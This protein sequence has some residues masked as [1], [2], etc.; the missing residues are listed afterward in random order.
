MRTTFKTAAEVV[1][2]LGAVQAQDYPGA[3]WGVGQRMKRASDQELDAAL[4]EGTI[5]RTH[6]MRPTWHFVP[7]TDIK[8]M[9]AL[10]GPRVNAAS[11]SAYRSQE[12]DDRVLARARVVLERA[13]RDHTYLT[14]AEIAKALQQARI[15]CN[16]LRLSL[17]V[18]R[19]EVDALICSGPRRG[20]H[21]TYALVDERAPRAKTLTRD[22]AL[23]ELTSRYFASHGPATIRDYVWWSGLTVREAKAGVAMVK[24][25]FEELSLG[26]LTY[27]FRPAKG[28]RPPD[29]PIVHLVPTYDE[30]LI[31]Y[32]DRGVA[33]DLDPSQKPPSTM[34]PYAA[35]VTIDGRLRGTWRRTIERDRIAVKVTPF[36]TLTTPQRRALEGEIERYSKF[37]GCAVKLDAVR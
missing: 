30:S 22:E 8:W 35:Y 3:K 1:S 16:P 25:A 37:M 20:K 19:A 24:P 15:L 31:A 32:K 17:I 18:M 4:D 23:A 28:V 33:L 29:T 27:F 21:F 7:T 14:R 6:V 26:G 12:L 2:W 13:L 5:L 34:D 36:L 11:G 9:Q 10:T